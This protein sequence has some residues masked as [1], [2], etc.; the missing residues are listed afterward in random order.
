MKN[1]NI[2]K[3]NGL[4][5]GRLSNDTPAIICRTFEDTKTKK[6][7]P[8][9]AL[10]VVLDCGN[11]DFVGDCSIKNILTAPKP[12]SKTEY[13]ALA[14]E[15]RQ[16]VDLKT[17]FGSY[18]KKAIERKPA[19]EG[20]PGALIHPKSAEQVLWMIV[21]GF[22][23]NDDWGLGA[24][25]EPFL[26]SGPIGAEAN[27]LEAYKASRKKLYENL[28]K[29]GLGENEIERILWATKE[30]SDFVYDMTKAHEK[31]KSLSELLEPDFG[32]I[33]DNIRDYARILE[34]TKRTP[35][36]EAIGLVWRLRNAI[37]GSKVIEA[38]FGLINEPISIGSKPIEITEEKILWTFED[39]PEVRDYFL[40]SKEL[41]EGPI[42]GQFDE[43]V[44]FI[45]G[46]THKTEEIRK[47]ITGFK[48]AYE[49][50][51][52]DKMREQW[53][54]AKKCFEK[55]I[56]L[57]KYPKILEKLSERRA[58]GFSGDVV[59]EYEEH[60]EPKFQ[61]VYTEEDDVYYKLLKMAEERGAKDTG[62]AAEAI[63][64]RINA[65]RIEHNRQ[66]AKYK[67]TCNEVKILRQR[68]ADYDF[69]HMI[70]TGRTKKAVESVEGL[71]ANAELDMEEL[72]F[73][74]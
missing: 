70:A 35:E 45:G 26:G 56:D 47:I 68:L 55:D 43:V 52:A 31:P 9:F 6:K 14:P 12:A 17:L 22:K 33:V 10:Q 2:S 1:Y 48:T 64:A 8:Y 67:K 72:G 57:N 51:Y 63:M 69:S 11:G 18:L 27:A 49:L 4:L 23:T 24:Y 19:P 21:S 7:I 61:K 34:Q 40:M 30:K 54:I 65:P 71:E 53:E 46:L 38:V 62:A 50:G 32:T 25:E 29:E 58:P 60:E 15:D 37:I 73:D 44:E 3:T 13:E 42:M 66:M 41:L 16:M 74:F 5:T 59:F 36:Q 39:L 20:I 28:V